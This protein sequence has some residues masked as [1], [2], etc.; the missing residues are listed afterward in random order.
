MPEFAVNISMIGHPRP[1]AERLRSVAEAGF[2]AIEFWFPHQFARVPGARARAV[3]SGGARN[4]TDGMARLTREL[5]L[6][7]A[8][9]DLEP[10]QSHPYGHWADPGAEDEFFRRLE[11]ALGTAERLGCRTLNVLQGEVLPEVGQERQMDCAVERLGRAARRAGEAGV[12][13]CVEAINTFDRPG[14]FCCTSALGLAIVQA[15]DS[16]WLRFQYDCY[17]MQLMEGDL[18]RTIERSAAWIGHVQVADPPGRHE[19]GTGEVNFENVLATLDRIGYRGVVS[20]EYWPSPG[21]RD[22]FAWL[23]REK[24]SLR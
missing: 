2:G 9:F 6:R 12:L 24:R 18:I 4:G 16:P 21:C 7:V 10:S 19:P 1:L 17:H 23:P 22:P 15:V 11:D 13:L 20:L 5:G 14:S 3:R 8:L